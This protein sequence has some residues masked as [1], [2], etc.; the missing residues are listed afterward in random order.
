MIDVGIVRVLE[1]TVLEGTVG[2]TAAR[3]K[4]VIVIVIVVVV[5]VVVV[6]PR[7]TLPASTAPI[8]API[9]A[10]ALTCCESITQVSL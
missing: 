8:N 3:S 6:L 9:T 10:S 2:V 1:E 7:S 4:L 5:V